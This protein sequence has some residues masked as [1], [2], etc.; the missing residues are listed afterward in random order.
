MRILK[1]IL[2]GGCLFL[3]SCQKESKTANE[4]EAI[5]VD[6]AVKRFD[7]DFATTTEATLANTKSEYPYLFPAHFPD[8]VWIA[9]LR[10]TLQ[11]QLNQAV[12]E[13]FE[14]FSSIEN[15]FENLFK[16]LQYYT[17]QLTIPKVVTVT[18]YV[19]YR[20][21]IIYAD[22]LLLISLD[23]YL[24]ENHNFYEGI[25]QYIRK[26]LTKDQILPDAVVAMSAELLPPMT[27]RSFLSQIIRQGKKLYLMDKVIPW[28]EDSTKIG[29]TQKEYEWARANESE[30]WR[31]FVDRKLLF[32][33]D[34]KLR[35]RFV[36][37]APFSKFYLELDTESPGRVGAYMG[38]QIVRA[39]MENNDVSLQ[40]MFIEPEETLFTKSGFKPRKNG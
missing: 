15:D 1:F 13:E 19:D 23:T 40:Q 8:S 33:T 5:K 21:K 17:P 2:L 38:W 10:D 36:D 16:H 7:L 18:S 4:I 37:P 31:Y 30:I 29:Y 9:Q 24:G 35:A 26:N 3:L 14:D 27:S 25:Q 34:Q 28:V 22:T 6:V 32:S 20:K 39:F 11:V 12:R